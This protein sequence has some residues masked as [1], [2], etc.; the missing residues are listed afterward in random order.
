MNKYAYYFADLNVGTPNPQRVSVIV[1]TGSALCGFPC[2]SCVHCGNHIDP[3]FDFAASKSANAV[4][5][6]PECDGGCQQDLC[7]YRQSYAEGSY[8]TGFFF[9]DQAQLADAL[10][11]NTPVNATLGCHIDERKLFFTQRVNGIMGLAPRQIKDGRPTI[12]QELFQDK[13]HVSTGM[14]SMCLA[15]WGGLLT[16]GGYHPQYHTTSQSGLQWIPMTA[17]GYYY[18]KPDKLLLGDTPLASTFQE[19]GDTIVDSGTTFTYLPTAVFNK[20]TTA[21][22]AYCDKEPGCGASKSESE[23]NCWYVLDSAAGPAKFPKLSFAFTTPEGVISVQWPASAYLYQRA[24]VGYWCRAF[25]DNGATQSS[26][27]GV[28]WML[29]KDIVFDIAG[30]RLGVSEAACPEHKRAPGEDSPGFVIGGRSTSD[31]FRLRVTPRSLIFGGGAVVFGILAVILFAY[32]F[33]IGSDSAREGMQQ[34]KTGPR[35]DSARD[36]DEL[37]NQL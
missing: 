32:A 18:V 19:F 30:S 25:S 16:V 36:Y 12:L 3:L 15:E 28:S 29:H 17:Q 14:F 21:I 22:D 10:G 34:P 23:P 37:Q 13:T 8:V 33:C 20:L 4:G 35:L 5:C 24:V 6:T 26:V 2:A 11:D 7:A 9:K 31:G 1:D 27:F